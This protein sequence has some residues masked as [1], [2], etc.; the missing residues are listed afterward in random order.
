MPGSFETLQ[1]A[2]HSN[3]GDVVIR[4]LFG[5][6]IAAVVF[7]FGVRFAFPRVSMADHVNSDVNRMVDQGVLAVVVAMGLTTLGIAVVSQ[8][9]RSSRRLLISI[10]LELLLLGSVYVR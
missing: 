9:A 10:G 6:A 8:P 4:I 5:V 3:R 1:T 7:V 2:Q